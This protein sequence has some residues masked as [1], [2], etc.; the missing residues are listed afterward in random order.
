MGNNNVLSEEQVVDIFE[1]LK[2]QS[3]V[4]VV[5]TAVPRP[6]RD[7]NNGLISQVSGRYSN[8]RVVD[9]A[10][11]AQGHP[12]YFAPDGVHLVGAGVATYVA[13]IAKY[14]D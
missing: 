12:E 3:R 6:W 11:I 13:E 7:G 5:N 2:E 8:V 1:A 4:I 9:W 14:L 10:A